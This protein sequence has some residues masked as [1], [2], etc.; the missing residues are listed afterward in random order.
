MLEDVP[1]QAEYFKEN[2]P[3]PDDYHL[4]FRVYLPNQWTFQ[5]ADL[6]SLVIWES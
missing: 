4:N 2:S 3:R 5:F 6:I 1:Y